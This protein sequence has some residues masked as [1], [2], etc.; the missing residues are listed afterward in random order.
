MGMPSAMV[1]FRFYLDLDD[2]VAETTRALAKMA[3]R[4]FGKNVRFEDMSVFDLS[5]SLGLNENEF[6]AFMDAAHEPDFL[7][8]LPVVPGARPTLG[9]WREAG[10][11]IHIITGR[12]PTS[13]TATLEWLEARSI[14]F[15]GLEFVDKYGRYSGTSATSRDDLRL[16]GFHAAVEDADDAALDL[17]LHT[18]ALVLLYDRPWNQVSEAE[19]H[20]AIRVYG[21]EDVRR[22]IEGLAPPS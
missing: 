6:P 1:N 4:R 12:P 19:T 9:R 15:D 11:Q 10:A 8:N 17:A 13:R 5:L 21:W 16:R 20:G 18:D 2:V 14:P 7:R 22:R 3:H